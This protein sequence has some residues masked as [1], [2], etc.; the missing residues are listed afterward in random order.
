MSRSEPQ[1]VMRRAR[2]DDLAVIVRMLADDALG[3]KRERFAIPL[4]E[5]YLRAFEAIDADPNNELIIASR[6]D[7]FVG[8][9]QLTFIPS[10][11]YMGQALLRWA[12]ERARSRGCRI[13]QLTTDKARRDARR[14]YE[15]LVLVAS[16][17]G[18][19][20]HLS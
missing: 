3:S 10:L 7:G 20:L 19:K 18:L 16:H 13:V 2:Q 1:L 9:L 14:V 4:A 8:V 5:A 6:E 12:I 17:E 15:R 11:T